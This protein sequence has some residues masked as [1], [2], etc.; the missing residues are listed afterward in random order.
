MITYFRSLFLCNQNYKNIDSLKRFHYKFH[1][2]DKGCLC[3]MEFHLKQEC[4]PVGCVPCAAV[5]VSPGGWGLLLGVSGLGVSGPGVS[6]PGGCL[7]L[8]GLLSQHALRQTPLCG[9]THACENITFATSLRTVINNLFCRWQ[10]FAHSP[11]HILIHFFV[12]P[13]LLENDTLT[14]NSMDMKF[15]LITKDF[16]SIFTHF[17]SWF[18]CSPLD[19]NTDNSTGYQ[20]K[21]LH[22]GKGCP[23]R[24][25]SRLH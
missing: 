12:F 17:R 6:A 4:I 15:D 18:L 1:H 11:F 16:I 22:F 2:C 24:R 3:Y 9:Q 20:S 23:G 8:G 25:G 7:V 19:R 5:A 21:F 13:S 14:K 10:I